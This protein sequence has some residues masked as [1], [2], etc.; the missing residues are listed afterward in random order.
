MCRPCHFCAGTLLAPA[1][2]APGLCSPRPL[3]AGTATGRAEEVPA[4]HRGAAC[5]LGEVQVRTRP[6]LARMW[7]VPA[8]MLL[9]VSGTRA[10]ATAT[11]RSASCMCS[12]HA[13]ASA[14]RFLGM[15]PGRSSQSGSL[16]LDPAAASHTHT[17][18]A[19]APW[20]E[21]RTCELK[22]GLG[23]RSSEV[24]AGECCQRG[25]VRRE[26][27]VQGWPGQQEGRG[28]AR[29]DS[30]TLRT[31]ARKPKHTH[32]HVRTLF[33]HPPHTRR[34]QLTHAA[35]HTYSLWTL[36]LFVCF[37]RLPPSDLHCTPL[38][39][40]AVQCSAVQLRLRPTTLSAPNLRTLLADCRATADKC[41]RPLRTCTLARTLARTLTHTL[42]RTH[43]RTRT[44]TLTRA[45]M[46]LRRRAQPRPSRRHGA[47]AAHDRPVG[48][49]SRGPQ[50]HAVR[51]PVHLGHKRN[52]QDD[53]S[54]LLQLSTKVSYPRD[55]ARPPAPLRCSNSRIG[56]PPLLPLC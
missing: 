21:R 17:R 5:D 47:P 19:V 15:S 54:K 41:L 13:C 29:H 32:T 28:T 51:A 23:G 11:R 52:L 40:H 45:L 37:W 43:A 31:H 36:P 27:G 56:K 7:P 22:R 33:L 46:A 55:Q 39:Q 24:G 34:G 44:H 1:T 16:A 50:R 8:Q 4:R 26:C 10:P 18:F 48:C 9:L 30:A 25:R 6:V 49:R 38:S 42:T 20:W 35:A 53:L 3:C 14:A 2:S 12:T